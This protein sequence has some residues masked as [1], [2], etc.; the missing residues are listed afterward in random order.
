MVGDVR[1]VG[2]ALDGWR[3]REIESRAWLARTHAAR[4]AA[5]LPKKL[6]L[7]CN[8][9]TV[10]KQEHRSSAAPS[11]PALPPLLDSSKT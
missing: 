8:F 1:E 10:I 7:V 2:L 3:K 11:S 9:V 5:T 4:G 6:R